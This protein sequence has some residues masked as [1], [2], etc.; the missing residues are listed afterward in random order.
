MTDALVAATHE[1]I[2]RLEKAMLDNLPLVDLPI[3]HRFTPGLY[4]REMFA[5]KGTLVTSM[6]HRTEHQFVILEGS[7]SIYNAETGDV[8]HLKAPYIG[9]TKPGTR[10]VAYIH[11]DCRWITFHPLV[12]GEETES[13]LPKIEGRIIERRELEDGKTSHEIHQAL[14]A[15]RSLPAPS[16]GDAQ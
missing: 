15:E 12:E 6:I 9:V 7:L 2:D 5:P 10:R 14:M 11:E 3:V 13:D 1:K 16:E 8:A 4:A